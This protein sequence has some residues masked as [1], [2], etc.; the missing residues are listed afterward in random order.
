MIQFRA[1]LIFMTIQDIVVQGDEK[2]TELSTNLYIPEIECDSI[3]LIILRPEDLGDK[4]RVCASHYVLF[5]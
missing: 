2:K 4:D 1:S 5:C 3:D